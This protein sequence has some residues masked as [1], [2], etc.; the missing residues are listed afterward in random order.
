M[1][2]NLIAELLRHSKAIAKLRV[3]DNSRPDFICYDGLSICWENCIFPSR[4]AIYVN[5][6]LL[7]PLAL[8][9]CVSKAAE[10]IR[11]KDYP[12]LLYLCEEYHQAIPDDI[13]REILIREGF[14]LQGK[15]IGMSAIISLSQFQSDLELVRLR[16]ERAQGSS[17]LKDFA[18]I[19]SLA[20]DKELEK[21]RA[22]M[23]GK[24]FWNDTTFAYVGYLDGQP[25]STAAGIKN[26]NCLYLTYVATHPDFQRQG[27]A[28]EAILHTLKQSYEASSV[29]HTVLYSTSDGFQLYKRLGYQPVAVFNVYLLENSST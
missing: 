24:Q 25:V 18:A 20:Y 9:V 1:T 28:R 12:G 23:P 10:Y 29:D 14:E 15:L 22:S 8:Q 11:N 4:N 16:F 6:P 26:E 5:E 2:E 7:S 17:V 3:L 19:Y 21:G 13:C 27:F